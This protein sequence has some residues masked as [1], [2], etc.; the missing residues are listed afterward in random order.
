[1]AVIS[2][3]GNTTGVALV[4]VYELTTSTANLAALSCRAR[5]GTN[6]D[7]LIPGITIAGSG[8]KQVIIRASGPALAAQGVD[9]TLA[10]LRLQVFNSAGTKIA[11]N[12]G[13]ENGNNL[14]EL[15]TATLAS[16]LQPFRAGSA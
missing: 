10:Q 9:G 11:E 1:T 8:A 5:V 4:E 14:D 2:G 6:A 3:L 12:V 7:I 15:A 13:W 16:G